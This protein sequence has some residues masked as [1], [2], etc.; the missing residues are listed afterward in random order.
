MIFIPRT[1]LLGQLSRSALNNE[2]LWTH[3]KQALQEFSSAQGIVLSS[4]SLLQ[5][6]QASM[7]SLPLQALITFNHL[8]PPPLPFPSSNISRKDTAGSAPVKNALLEGLRLFQWSQTPSPLP[9]LAASASHSS[10]LMPSS[11]AHTVIPQ[12]QCQPLFGSFL[13]PPS[14]AGTMAPVL[15][16]ELVMSRTPS[17]DNSAPPSVGDATTPPPLHPE[18]NEEPG[19][20]MANLSKLSNA[21]DSNST[22]ASPQHP[23]RSSQHQ[24]YSRRPVVPKLRL[25]SSLIRAKPVEYTLSGH[26]STTSSCASLS[27]ISTMDSLATSSTRSTRSTRSSVFI[28]PLRPSGAPPSLMSPK[29]ALVLGSPKGAASNSTKLHQSSPGSVGSSLTGSPRA[30]LRVGY[31]GTYWRSDS[32]VSRASSIS[33]TSSLYPQPKLFVSRPP[34]ILGSARDTVSKP[35]PSWKQNTGTLVQDG[36]ATYLL[37]N[38]APSQSSLTARPIPPGGSLR[39]ARKIAKDYSSKLLGAASNTSLKSPVKSKAHSPR[40]KWDRPQLRSMNSTSIPTERSKGLG[41]A[42]PIA[43]H[44]LS[45][46]PSLPSPRSPRRRK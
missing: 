22:A 42:S 7:S 38:E 9:L 17:L 1:A 32:S 23:H 3:T 39:Y 40:P 45:S 6:P 10:T 11:S 46:F 21:S 25:Q 16:T 34:V 44:S 13:H 26:S 37:L 19:H 12:A 43:V 35:K 29:K 14:Q 27:S 33:S 20:S 15:E 4:S 41:E 2:F 24:W 36:S 18:S 28:S 30:R 5:R 31:D 8:P